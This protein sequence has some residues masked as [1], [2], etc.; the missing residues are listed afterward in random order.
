TVAKAHELAKVGRNF[1]T[2]G[3]GCFP[4]R[5]AMLAVIARPQDFGDLV[6]VRGRSG[7]GAAVPREAGLDVAL[8][9]HDLAAQV[10]VDLVRCV[11]LIEQV[12]L[13]GDERVE[14]RLPAGA[15]DSFE[16]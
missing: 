3:L 9:L 1:G 15:A 4:G 8:Q 2:D 11:T 6:V 5:A 16:G 13:A 10:G 7:D 14:S 12:E